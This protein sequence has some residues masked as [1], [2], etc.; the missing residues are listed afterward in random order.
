MLKVGITG[1]IGSGKTTVC[2]LFAL[3]GVPVYNADERARSITIEN[4]LVKTQITEAFGGDSYLPDGSYNRP[5]ISEI[6]FKDSTKLAILNSIIHPAVREDGRKWQDQYSQHPYILK[7]A[8]LLF[9]SGSYRDLD[10]IIFVS[11]PES[12]RVQRVMSRDNTSESA[13]KDRIQKQMPDDEK[14]SK[15]DFVILNDGT[16]S[17]IRQVK[18]LHR[19]LCAYSRWMDIG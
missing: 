6:V 13:V 19:S 16:T 11:A 7:E 3:M 5:Y 4:T 2:R 10:K 8:A 14:R 18:T 17:L 9:E 12:I 15:S 1:G